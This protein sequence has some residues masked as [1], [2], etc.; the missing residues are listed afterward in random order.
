M[1]LTQGSG[2]SISSEAPRPQEGPCGP[3]TQEGHVVHVAEYG[4]RHKQR[5]EQ[6]WQH[7][8]REGEWQTDKRK[9]LL[10]RQT[11]KRGKTQKERTHNEET[12]MTLEMNLVT[13]AIAFCWTSR[14]TWTIQYCQYCVCFYFL[15]LF[16]YVEF[17]C[18]AICCDI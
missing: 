9:L 15:K 5:T 1:I 14:W 18:F 7:Q 6:S 13:F 3:Q 10:Q 17:F 12:N 8:E 16:C 2:S 4:Q 11:R